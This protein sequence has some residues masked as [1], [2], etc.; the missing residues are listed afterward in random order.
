MIDRAEKWLPIAALFLF[1]GV[2]WHFMTMG[3]DGWWYL[4]LGREICDCKCL[5]EYNNL[6]FTGHWTKVLH[7]QWL[8][9]LFFYGFY[10][11]GSYVAVYAITA[12]LLAGAF[13]MVSIISRETGGSVAAG[14]VFTFLGALSF[15]SYFDVR[16]E[17]II[18]I[19][20]A[21]EVWLMTRVISGKRAPLWMLVPIFVVWANC[22]SSLPMSIV[23]PLLIL[24]GWWIDRRRGFESGVKQRVLFWFVIAGAAT[25][26]NPYGP[27]IYADIVSRLISASVH[28]IEIF[29]SPDFHDKYSILQGVWLLLLWVGVIGSSERTRATD[30]TVLG[31]FS[32]LYLNGQRYFIFLLLTS[33]PIVAVHWGDIAK[34]WFRSPAWK[35]ALLAACLGGGIYLLSIPRHFH[36]FIVDVRTAANYMKETGVEGHV[37]NYYAWG[38]YLL[39]EHPELSIFIDGRNNIYEESGVFD[40]YRTAGKGGSY[41]KEVFYTYD[42]NAVIWPRRQPRL[43]NALDADPDWEPLYI[44]G[45]AAVFL[46][47]TP[48]NRVILEK[49]RAIYP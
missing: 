12:L 18:D 33:V 7:Q 8:A 2:T 39:W 4:A 5:P 21:I 29:H 30:L 45:E 3:G 49:Y 48:Q 25:L 37:F 44:R 11:I 15:R 31:A 24:S 28:A 35:I 13:G 16:S 26:L 41:W 10:R 27:K 43:L 38:G 46:R 1:Y 40:D 36:D 42:I 6:A 34:K 23:Y 9:Y 47:T 17:P 14:I 19:L 32:L 22:H 20:F